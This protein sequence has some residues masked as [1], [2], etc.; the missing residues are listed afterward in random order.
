M[1]VGHWPASPFGSFADVMVER[2]DGHRLLLAPSDDVAGF[3]AA[4]YRFDEVRI[5]PVAIRRSSDRW[6]VA[7]GPLELDLT[8]GSRTWLGRLL[9]LVPGALATSLGWAHVTGLV[10]R[11]LLPGVRTVGTAGG[12]R[13]ERYGARDVRRVL[14][15]R[16][17][18]EGA[19]LGNLRPVRPAPRFGF[20]STPASPSVVDVVTTV[21][22]PRRR[23]R[24]AR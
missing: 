2:S 15:V 23:F 16:A 8:L 9:R 17:R 5:T 22:A 11:L 7:A 4:T 18:W 14:A 21:W 12:G 10:A 6:E 19:D 1:V 20:S 24:R 13:I 3:V